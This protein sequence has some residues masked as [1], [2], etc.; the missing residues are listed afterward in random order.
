VGMARN[1]AA[2]AS[3]ARDFFPGVLRP[4]SSTRLAIKNS[5]HP[6]PQITRLSS[7]VAT[8]T[9]S[10]SCSDRSASSNT[11]ELPNQHLATVRKWPKL[12]YDTIHLNGIRKTSADYPFSEEC[13]IL[14]DN[15]HP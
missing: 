14:S 8:S 4:S 5:G 1:A 9:Q 3:I 11:C 6:P 2:K 10:A 13:T 7:T 12:W 15:R